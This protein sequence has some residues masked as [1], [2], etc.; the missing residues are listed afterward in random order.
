M[1]IFHIYDD[2]LHIIFTFSGYTMPLPCEFAILGSYVFIQIIDSL[3]FR[4]LID[5]FASLYVP[6]IRNKQHHYENVSKL[7]KL[8]GGRAPKHTYFLSITV[9]SNFIAFFLFSFILVTLFHVF[10]GFVQSKSL[11]TKCR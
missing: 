10:F 6:S 8:I 2:L 7:K 1:Y 3:S 4:V 11:S 5:S 9:A